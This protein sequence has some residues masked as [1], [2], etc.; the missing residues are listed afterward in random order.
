MSQE[1]R[2]WIR[3]VQEK[4][5]VGII[6]PHRGNGD[7]DDDRPIFA[8]IVNHC[9]GG[10]M[11]ETSAA[12]PPGR[13]F[14]LARYD[15]AGRQWEVHR[16]TVAWTEK[17]PGG[18]SHHIG[19]E[20]ASPAT[21]PG[22]TENSAMP[23]ALL[24]DIEFLLH[25]ALLDA[26][27]RS[28]IWSLLACLDRKKFQAG[29]NLICQG[30]QGD[31]LYLI[32]EGTCAVRVGKDDAFHQVALLKTGAVAGEMAVL[33][34]EPRYADVTAE[35][36]VLAWEL[37]KQQFDMV[38]AEHPDIRF[39]L[40]ELVTRRLETSTHVADR[41]IGRYLIKSKIAH[42][43][44][45]IV[46]HGLHQTLNRNVAIKMLKHQMA[47]DG[48]FRAK[49]KEEAEIIARMNH[50]NII[51]VYDVEEQYQTMFI[52]MEFIEGDSLEAV[53]KR[54]GK[55]P[56]PQAVHFLTQ[57][58]CAL[59]YAHNKGIV[60]QDIKPA[61]ILVQPN[62]QLKILDFGLACAQGAADM[63]MAG[64]V[65]YSAP[66]QIE[67]FAVDGRT[68]LYCLGITAFEMVT[69][70]RPYPED[71]LLALMDLHLAEEIPDPAGLVDHLPEILRD[72]IVTAC[73]RE[74]D[75]RYHNM[76]EALA[77]LQPLHRELTGGESPTPPEKKK[78]TSIY[79]FYQDEQ[80]GDLNRLLDDFSGK[81]QQLGVVLRA[82]EIHNV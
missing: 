61:N 48:D 36:D 4:G 24:N 62:G 56:V 17:S 55:L 74:P 35:T 13:Q 1:R 51:Q 16:F 7:T 52:I 5:G 64:T 46:Y 22:K 76:D 71:D 25:T 30:E 45:G 70:R 78:M 8:G 54:Q 33:T 57:M 72:F 77:V 63:C 9:P 20:L 2:Q 27:P 75:Q 14:S 47:M 37:G 66:E 34:G 73:R 79:L 26:I 18:K 28:A 59:A 15:F 81:A 69:G 23:P 12:L 42:G 44:W 65:Q 68:D 58:C 19:L 50:K 39:F 60:H 53:L 38:S 67:G 43:G 11:A 21:S 31:G 3:T 32:Q 80:Q 6:L 29:E 41:T 10:L 82:A 49:F 40:T